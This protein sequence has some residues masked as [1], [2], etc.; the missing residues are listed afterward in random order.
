MKGDAP[1]NTASNVSIAPIA[2]PATGSVEGVGR[3]GDEIGGPGGRIWTPDRATPRSHREFDARGGWANGFVRAPRG[4]DVARGLDPA[5]PASAFA[6]RWRSA[7]CPCW[8]ARSPAASCRI[9]KSAR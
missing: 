4:L 3:L 9:R 7:R 5:P 8:P 1:M 2:E 6:S